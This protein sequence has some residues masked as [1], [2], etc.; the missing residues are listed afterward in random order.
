VKEAKVL[1]SKYH[2]GL[3]WTEACWVQRW[4]TVSKSDLLFA[5]P[6]CDTDPTDSVIVGERERKWNKHLKEERSKISCFQK[7]GVVGYHGC[8]KERANI[9]NHFALGRKKKLLLAVR[10]RVK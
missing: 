6:C 8:A 9:T 1:L 2:D 5:I 4:A 7:L 10:G 3:R